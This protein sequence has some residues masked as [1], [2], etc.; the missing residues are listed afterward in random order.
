V[1]LLT[2]RAHF[3]Q[4]MPRG[5]Y[6]FLKK[7]PTGVTFVDEEG[8]ASKMPARHAGVLISADPER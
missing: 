6:T 4:V 1:A 5:Q 2:A 7:L 8:K 3:L